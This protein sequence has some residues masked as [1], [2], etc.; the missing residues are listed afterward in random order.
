VHLYLGH[1]ASKLLYYDNETEALRPDLVFVDAGGSIVFEINELGL[2]GD[3]RDETRKLAVVWGDSVVFGA[4]RGW[5]CLLDDLVSGYQFLNGGIEG[6]SFA[7]ILRR[8]SEMNHRQAVALNLVML[9]WHPLPDNR[10]V[11]S[12]LTA[13]LDSA[14]NTI[15]VTMPTALNRRIA[16][17][18]LSCYVA[19]RDGPDAF[20]FCGNLP[21]SRELQSAAFDYISERNQIVRDISRQ[22]DTP[23]V[24]LFREFDT[25]HLADFRQEFSDMIHLRPSAYPK[26]ARV[27]YEGIKHRLKPAISVVNNSSNGSET[28]AS[29]DQRQPLHKTRLA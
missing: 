4:G 15:L 19:N 25:E 28:V 21:Y 8:A 17:L 26:I 9:G 10:N 1:H 24:D 13:F 29:I 7:N 5:P 6:D 22:T 20:T 12:A 16:R 23:L 27:I 11:R 14:P 3:A 18:D 2:K